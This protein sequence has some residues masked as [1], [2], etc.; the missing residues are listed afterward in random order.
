MAFYGLGIVWLVSWLERS[1]SKSAG[2]RNKVE[3]AAKLLL[4]LLGM[5]SKPAAVTS[6]SY[7]WRLVLAGQ[8]RSAGGGDRS[9]SWA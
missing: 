9:S 1:Q 4:G 2:W 6:W 5:G 3:E 7:G 8:L